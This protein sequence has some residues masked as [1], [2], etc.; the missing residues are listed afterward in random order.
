MDDLINLDYT[1]KIFLHC[2][3]EQFYKEEKAKL[4]L[5]MS[6]GVSNG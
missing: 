1:E 3:R 4:D 2:A 5:A 6:K